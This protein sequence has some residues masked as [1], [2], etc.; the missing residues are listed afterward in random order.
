[1]YVKWQDIEPHRRQQA[2]AEDY[3]FFA[4]LEWDFYKIFA[5]VLAGT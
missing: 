2:H 5:A 4:A 1:M 3:I